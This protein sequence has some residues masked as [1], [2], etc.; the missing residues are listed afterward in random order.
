MADTVR[1]Q[2]D[3]LANLF[4]DG[5]AA[6]SI[7]AQDV[8]D[9]IVSLSPSFGSTSMQGNTTATSISVA[10]TYVKVAGTTTLLGNENSFDDDSSISNRLRYTGTPTRHCMVE[11][12]VSFEATSN[13]QTVAFKIYKYDDSATSGA[14]IDESLVTRFVANSGQIGVVVLMVDV[15]LDTNDYLEV[16]VT[17]ETSTV[18][19]TVD[20]MYFRVTG[21]IKT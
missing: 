1:T 15:E 9:L 8:R 7:T 5:Q 6:G 10:G 4:Q 2:S 16:H 3:L 18:N 13:N 17:N 20:D 11:A 14:L 19:V 21:H 12:S